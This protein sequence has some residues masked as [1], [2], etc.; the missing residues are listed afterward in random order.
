[1]Y[2]S[3]SSLIADYDGSTI[4]LRS[5]TVT[6]PSDEMRAI[7]AAADVGDDVYGEDPSII[8]L[9]EK[10]AAMTG[11][12]AGLFLPSCT[13]SNL[14]AMLCHAARGEEIILGKGYHIYKYEAGGSAVLGGAFQCA[15]DEDADGGLDPE[16]VRTAIKPD[17]PHFPISKVLS[18]E[19]TTSGKAIALDRLQSSI[20]VARSA[21]MNVHLDGARFFNATTKLNVSPKQLA[22]PFDTV[23]LCM[24]KGLGA[25]VGAVL[26]GSKELM[27]R[28]V[29]ARKIVGGGMRQAG[30]LA[31]AC[32]YALDNHIGDLAADH[33]R[34]QTLTHEL[35]N[36]G[37]INIDPGQTQTNMLFIEVDETDVNPLRRY[38]AE[39]G[40]NLAGGT[41]I[42]IVMHRDIDDDGLERT[43]NAFKG[44]YSQ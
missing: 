21:N 27:S 40:I 25:P 41:Q 39:R 42:R 38:L 24:S 36:I 28:A 19:N 33:D 8:A 31:A 20:D 1:M 18:L 26:V 9:E 5:D 22:A 44:F 4:D 17:D 43:I 14:V 16:K 35:S 7:M 34:A 10:L 37:A 32:I 3:M 13:M 15:L 30:V 6:K 29:R 12:E 11:K 23:S 2:D